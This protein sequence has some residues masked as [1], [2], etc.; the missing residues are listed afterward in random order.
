MELYINISDLKPDFEG[1]EM[2]ACF[3][4]FKPKVQKTIRIVGEASYY[5]GS[6]TADKKI[7]PED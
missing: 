5:R 7:T 3:K 6:R 4:D 2:Y 1:N